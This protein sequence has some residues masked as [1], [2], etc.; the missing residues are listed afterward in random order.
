M[1]GTFIIKLMIFN[2]LP[3]PQ[4]PKNISEPK[5]AQYF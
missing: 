3:L 1:G 5:L 4:I 2:I